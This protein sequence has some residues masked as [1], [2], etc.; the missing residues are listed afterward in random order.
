MNLFWY[1]SVMKPINTLLALLFISLLSS[2]SWSVTIDDL[3]ERNGLYYKKFTDVPFSA[4]VTGGSRQG[5]FKNGK[6][7]GA[8]VR[9]WEN[10]QLKDKNNFKNGKRE[11]TS[12]AYHDDGQLNEK[13]NY[14]DDKKEGAWI[15]Y[16][17]NGQL[18]LKG[19]FKNGKEDGVFI[20]YHRDGQLRGKGN[21]KNGKQEGATV[22]YNKDG[23]VNKEGTGTY[24]DGK[25]ISD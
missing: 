22:V 25:K 11:G 3:V 9:Y 15:H 2:P 23:T 13:G 10:G 12:V 20:A 24:K 19:N 8:W 1:S 18:G 14:K 16:W 7:E 5:S 6:K 4:K 17:K 21:L